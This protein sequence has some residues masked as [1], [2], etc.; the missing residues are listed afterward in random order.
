MISPALEKGV[1]SILGL[2]FIK[3]FIGMIK[4]RTCSLLVYGPFLNN[5]D[6]IIIISTRGQVLRL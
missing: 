2:S 3:R 6:C 4:S 5:N 1:Y